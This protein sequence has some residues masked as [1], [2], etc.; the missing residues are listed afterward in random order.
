MK[1]LLTSIGLEGNVSKFFLDLYWQD[2]SWQL[3][4]DGK[5]I[6]LNFHG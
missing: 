6:N 4:G 5:L 1:L 2:R 3:V